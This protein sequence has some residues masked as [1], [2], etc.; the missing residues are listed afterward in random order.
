[1]KVF[2]TGG[3]GF[4]GSAVV[5]RLLERGD[6]VL[7]LARSERAAAKLTRLGAVPL[8][9]DITDAGMLDVAMSGVDAVFHIA[10]QY[11]IGISGVR[12]RGDVPHQRGRHDAGARRSISAP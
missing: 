10:G 1:M 11:R 6:E 7:G 4:L 3:A 9:G 5:A 12:A 8:R 2:V